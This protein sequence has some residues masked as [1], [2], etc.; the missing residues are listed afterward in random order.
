MKL[1]IAEEFAHVKVRQRVMPDSR[2]EYGN[3]ES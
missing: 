3:N 1:L 2:I